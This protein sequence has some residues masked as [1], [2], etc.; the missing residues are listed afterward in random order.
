M[1]NR[2]TTR[3]EIEYT[4]LQISHG[5]YLVLLREAGTAEVC[6]GT[7]LAIAYITIVYYLRGNNRVE[8]EPG[9]R[10]ISFT[11]DNGLNELP[12]H[13]GQ[14]SIWSPSSICTAAALHLL[15]E[16]GL[17]IIYQQQHFHW[18]VSILPGTMVKA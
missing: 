14:L 15:I 10:C 17:Q 18:Y 5:S 7:M 8:L 2:T 13:R 16:T 9:I 1:L 4:V 12:V 3:D 11:H 6:T